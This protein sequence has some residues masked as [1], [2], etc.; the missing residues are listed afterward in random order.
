M[1][2]QIGALC[3]ASLL[4]GLCLSGFSAL[5]EEGRG[6]AWV[7][8]FHTS[9]RLTVVSPQ[10]SVKAPVLDEAD[11]EAAMDVDIITAATVDV[12][13]A[14]SPRGYS[15]TRHG[16]SVGGTYH[17]AEG[18][19]IGLSYIPSFEP[20]YVSHGALAHA[21]TEWIDR[22]LTVDAA[23]RFARD[24]VGRTGSARSEWSDL[25]VHGASLTFSWVFDPWMVGQLNYEF[26]AQFGYMESPY[27]YVPLYYAGFPG[28]ISVGES[29]PD[30]RLRHAL[31]GDLRRA[32]GG[33]FFGR[34]H[35]RF[36]MDSWG[37]LSHTEE[38]ELQ[39]A[40]LAGHLILGIA[41]RI[42]GQ[43]SASFYRYRYTSENDVPSAVPK[44]RSADKMLSSQWTLLAG[45]RIEVSTGAAGPFSALRLTLKAEFYEQRFLN[46]PLLNERTALMFSGGAAGEY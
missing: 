30:T 19:D 3:I 22:R 13:A 24:R 33:G 16:Y 45:P 46:F 27:R 8:V 36:Y 38:F 35:L 23:Y 42:Y 37:V 28:P 26:Q 14:A 6:A 5:A 34:S 18:A 12:V 10:L 43:G 41:A 25:S 4:A 40:M 20:D 9:D 29:V 17:A 15:E 7:S 32:L 39:R 31:S 2:L 11:I 21:S 1:R 44:F